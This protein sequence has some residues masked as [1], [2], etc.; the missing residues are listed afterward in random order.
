MKLNIK[1][2]LLA[3]VTVPMLTG[4]LDST[5]ATDV[6][7]EDQ[8]EASSLGGDALFWGM[9]AT[10]NYV[11]TIPV[12]NYAYDYGYGSIMHI[13]D[14]LTDDLA[15]VSTSYEWYT[16][17]M[18]NT[19]LGDYTISAQL[20]WWYM[21]KLVLV[22]NNSIKYYKNGENDGRL[23]ASYA[24]RAATYL[25]M[26][27]MYEFLPNDGTSPVNTYGN[28]VQGLTVPI[29]TDETTQAEAT[30]NPRVTHEKMSEFILS[31]LDKAEELLQGYAREAKTIP[32]LGVVY[33]LKARLYMW[34]EDYAKAQEFAA[35]AI[36]ASGA[37]PLTQDEWLNT[38]SGFNDVSSSSWMWGAQQTTEDASV[39]SIYYNWTSW[40][41]NETTFGYCSYGT[42]VMI[43]AATYN[44][45]A[46][47]DFRKLSFIAPDDSPLS[48]QEPL[49]DESFREKFDTYYSLKFR[50]GQG[51]YSDYTIGAVTCYPLMRVEEMYLIQAEAAAHQNPAEGKQLIE[52]FMR[53]YRDSSYTCSATSIDD[54]VEE[55]V[56]QKR[57]ELWGEGQSYFDYKRLNMSV[58]RAY[59]GTNFTGNTLMNTNGRPAWMNFVILSWEGDNNAAVQKW[60]NPSPDNVYP[61]IEL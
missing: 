46:D 40:M 57:V 17:W 1:H 8:I 18:T 44:R 10:L 9:P 26:A 59:E 7:T 22:S 6:V 5:L 51:N 58:T 48:G 20:T 25:D 35:K 14:V 53:Q 3:A 12:S 45:I 15:K 41:C 42:N 38:S 60:N 54:V 39:T 31:D 11:G 29:V 47:T 32:D 50:P 34:N 28:N 55:I 33:G 56:F 13:R 16:S 2:I 43:N 23:G 27:R 36:A 4:C 30:N 61:T 49:V 52:E 21:N 37:T 19:G 24:F